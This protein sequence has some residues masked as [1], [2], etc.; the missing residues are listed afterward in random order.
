MVEKHS[1]WKKERNPTRNPNSE[2]PS[3]FQFL[4]GHHGLILNIPNTIRQKKDKKIKKSE[5]SNVELDVEYLK[6][7]IIENMNI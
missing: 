7:K 5:K 4:L 6:E 2:F 1:L 3:E